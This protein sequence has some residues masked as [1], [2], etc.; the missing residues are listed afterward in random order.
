MN[1]S[2]TNIKPRVIILVGLPAAGKS[3][4]AREL[5]KNDY[6]VVNQDMQGSRISCEVLMRAA[7][8][9]GLNVVVDKCNMSKKQ[10]A[11]W[12]KIAKHFDARV[13][14][15]LFIPHMHNSI[16][17]ALQRED[18]DT[19]AEIEKIIRRYQD[20]YQRPALDEGFDHISYRYSYDPSSYDNSNGSA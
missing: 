19:Y 15:V 18:S 16:K 7:L 3:T 1:L 20:E 17:N 4:L 14:C 8:R 12:I 10:R 11:A 13:E 2:V 5:E 6:C 9:A